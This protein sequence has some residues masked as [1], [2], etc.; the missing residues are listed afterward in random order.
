VRAEHAFVADHGHFQ[1]LPIV[2]GGPQ[3]DEALRRKVGV[4]QGPAGLAEHFC[5][6]ELHTL[7]LR[8]QALAVCAGQRI[9]ELVF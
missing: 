3:R 5:K 7:A 2:H 8:E 1:P 6:R 4:L 9:D